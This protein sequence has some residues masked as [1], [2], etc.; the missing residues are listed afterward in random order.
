MI[1]VAKPFGNHSNRLL[2]D[3]RLHAFCK[4][5]GIRYF[6]PHFSDM[7]RFY[8]N[9]YRRGY[10]GRHVIRLLRHLYLIRPVLLGLLP[11][12]EER[13]RYHPVATPEELLSLCQRYR[14]LFVC[15]FALPVDALLRKHHDTFIHQY[16]LDPRLLKGNRIVRQIS[17][18]KLQGI[19]VLGLHIR[20]GDYK[21]WREGRHYYDDATYSRIIDSTVK[22]FEARGHIVR[23]I[24]CSNEPVTLRTKCAPVFSGSEWYVDQYLLSQCNYILG[25]PSTFTEWASYIGEVPFYH[26]QSPIEEICLEKFKYCYK[27]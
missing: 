22:L 6:N 4:E 9:L 12:N 21:T 8:P 17:D 25:P 26:I 23:C 15:G 10:G 11:R 14:L 27:E 7:A 18:W 1:I 24:I 5:Y 13:H 16:A 20:R 19:V 3:A 2:Q